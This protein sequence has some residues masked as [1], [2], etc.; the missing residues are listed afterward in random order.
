MNRQTERAELRNFALIMAG[1]VALFFGALVPWLWS[2]RFPAWPWYV[3]I[4]LGA[5][6]LLAPLSLRL[7]Y[8]LW[9]RLGH[10]LGWLNTRLLLGIIF[11]LMI[12]PM[13]LAMRLFGR[14]PMRRRIDAAAKTY[15]V[16]SSP[17][18]RKNM[19]TPY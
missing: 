4:G 14:D 12:T 10:A 3:A 8:G 13:G 16:A 6:G 17:L 18:S 2:W 9:T 15:K 5:W 7:P 11:Y 19:E 1:M